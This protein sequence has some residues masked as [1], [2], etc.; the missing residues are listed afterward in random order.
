MKLRYYLRGLGIGIVVTA[1]IMTVA[2]S[3]KQL[4]TD[5]EVIKRAKELGM[6]ENTIIK[7]VATSK[8]DD[9]QVSEDIK[10]ETKENTQETVDEDTTEEVPEEIVKEPEVTEEPQE[11]PEEPTESTSDVIT[12]TVVGG[13][14]SWSVAKRIEEAGLVDSAKDFD[15]YLCSNGYDKRISVG[16]YEIPK[17]ASEE[18]MAKIITKMN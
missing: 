15:A 7:D 17:G 13:D 5:E 14:S 3:K 8:N 9:E 4:M 16:S 10:E 11:I 18:E 1:V 12:V 6:I 2:L